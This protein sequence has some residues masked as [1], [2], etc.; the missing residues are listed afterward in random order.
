MR[1]SLRQKE[2]PPRR[3]SADSRLRKAFFFSESEGEGN[4][5]KRQAHTSRRA[6][7]CLRSLRGD[8]RSSDSQGAVR[9]SVS[10]LQPALDRPAGRVFQ[11]I[12]ARRPA[13][14]YYL[15]LGRTPGAE[16]GASRDRQS[17]R[18]PGADPPV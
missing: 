4:A 18:R 2:E 17:E 16:I 9:R 14:L 6:L 5:D 11:K 7:F 8:G 12:S 13:D 10:Q 15:R 3:A 1:F